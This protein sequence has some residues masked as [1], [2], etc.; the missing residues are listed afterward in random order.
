MLSVRRGFLFLWVLV[1]GCVILLWHSMCLPY[2]YLEKQYVLIEMPR[3]YSKLQL[4]YISYTNS[5]ANKWSST[6]LKTIIQGLP[7][8]ENWEKSEIPRILS[9]PDFRRF[10]HWYKHYILIYL[11]ENKSAELTRGRVDLGRVGNRMS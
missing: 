10:H 3:C 2:N 6:Q 4:R 8:S 9:C 7:Q 1:V 11:K 5:S